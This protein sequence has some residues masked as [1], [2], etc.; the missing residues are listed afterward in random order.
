MIYKKNANFP[1]P[2][3]SATSNSY[4]D[5]Y[6]DLD[7]NVSENAED[8]YFE[9]EYTLDSE[10]M[11]SQIAKGKAELIL[12]IRSKDNK[13]YRIKQGQ[14]HVKIPKSR[15]S[16]NLR[17]SIQ[18]HIQA[19]DTLNFSDNEDLSPFYERV[20]EEITVPQFSLLGY[21]NIISFDGSLKKP[22]DIF[23]KKIDEN[24]K[25]DIKVELGQ[26]TII[27]HYKKG[28]YQFNHLPKSR[29]LNNPY[30]YTGLTKAL[31]AFI[32]N[33]S[34]EGD[35]DIENM[36]EPEGAL[37]FKLYNL[38]KN[39]KVYELNHDNIDEVIHMISDNIIDRYTSAVGEMV[40]NGN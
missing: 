7:V 4:V 24:L 21:S 31:Q 28:E 39:K 26:E 32:I 15:I 22:F 23:E 29:I 37:D 19:L 38:M 25:S 3:I 17:T 33:N 40:T 1:Y 35:I 27:I 34:D 36:D 2:I 5:N 12:I 20:R 18:L 14:S 8:Y 9:F 16:L 10:F 13:F 11:R 30:I 6:F